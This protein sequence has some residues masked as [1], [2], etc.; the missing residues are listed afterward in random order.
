MATV[1]GE[2]KGVYKRATCKNCGAVNEYTPQEVRVLYSGTDYGGGSDG[3]K[4]FNCAR[5]HQEIKTEVW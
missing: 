3:A 5:C 1:V 4:G 2:D